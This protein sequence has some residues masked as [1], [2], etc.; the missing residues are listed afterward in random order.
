MMEGVTP[1]HLSIREE[2]EERY[3]LLEK[4]KDTR[5]PG[6]GASTREIAQPG[7]WRRWPSLVVHDGMGGAGQ[8]GERRDRRAP[9]DKEH[10]HLSLAAA[11]AHCGVMSQVGRM[12]NQARRAGT[13]RQ[14]EPGAGNGEFW[15]L[16]RTR[17]VRRGQQSVVT[18]QGASDIQSWLG[19]PA[20]KRREVPEGRREPGSS[21]RAR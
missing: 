21:T 3:S 1:L 2:G 9:R 7:R 19:H 6:R 16:V 14:P 11:S 15:R 5:S 8:Q 12:P 10:Q 17:I 18:V 4:G 20:E 13:I